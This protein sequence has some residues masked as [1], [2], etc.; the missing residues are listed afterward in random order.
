MAAERSIC[1]RLQDRISIQLCDYRNIEGAY[2]KIVSI[3]MLEAVG[4]RYFGAFFKGVD[5]LLK[6]DG[7]LVL[8][9]ITFPDQ[10]YDYYRCDCDWIQKSPFCF[11]ACWFRYNRNLLFR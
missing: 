2:D 11:Q 8:Q 3:E 4:H 5:A 9:V 7:L 6:P 10:R 1:G